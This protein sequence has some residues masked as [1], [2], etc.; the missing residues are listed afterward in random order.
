MRRLTLG[1][2]AHRCNG[3]LRGADSETLVTGF[4]TDSREAAPGVVFIAIRGAKVDGHTFAKAALEQGAACVLA[5]RPVEGP[6]ILVDMV[7]EGLARLGRSIRD[8]FAGPV[9]GITGSTGKTTTKEFT[10]QACGALGPVLKSEGNRNTEWT[11][12]LV[13][14]EL[15]DQ[16]VAVIEMGMR[17]F[18]Q[19]AH[20]ASIAKPTIGIITCI[21]TG[22]VEMVGSRQGIAEAKS[23]LL[24]ALVDDGPAILWRE[25][26]FF[27]VLCTKAKGPIRTFGFSP[28]ADCRIIG[29]R[30]LDINH[31]EMIGELDGENF[32]VRLPAAGR[33]QALNAAA[34]LLATVAAGA[35]IQEAAARLADTKLPPMRFEAVSYRGATILIDT[36]NANPDSTTA[37]LR[38]LA[39]LPA[40]GRRMAVLGEMRELGDFEESGHRAV[41]RALAGA[42]LDRALMVGRPAQYIRD[43]AIQAGFP[44][45]QTD[46][47]EEVD[48]SRVRA[49]LDAVEP[50]DMVL[51]KGS[52]ALG[53]E[54]AL[55][56]EARL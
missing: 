50:G 20:L 47:S 18:G 40:T 16:K 36:Y 19:I 52:R 1:E 6:H 56:P 27:D 29:A 5:E 28:D 53:L 4:A 31:T 22:H 25:D 54:N 13:W 32:M 3:Q 11:S 55:P 42:E 24:A 30:T 15:V 49:F 26:E 34:A 46:W 44:A 7:Q 10:A 37:A 9:I 23:E 33:H 2:L 45:G 35:D 48:L 14:T 8:E 43:E 39:E 51:I 41:G 17:G 38:T 12:P 21:G